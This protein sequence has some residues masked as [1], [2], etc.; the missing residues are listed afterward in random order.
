MTTYRKKLMSKDDFFAAM[1]KGK[2]YVRYG[3][4]LKR[5]APKIMADA[6][7]W[8]A[9]GVHSQIGPR[10]ANWNIDDNDL[11][12]ILT[13]LPEHEHVASIAQASS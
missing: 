13:N 11:E 3:G 5:W 1:S 10:T 6:T 9:V 12:P 8:Q 2:P 4:G 7:N